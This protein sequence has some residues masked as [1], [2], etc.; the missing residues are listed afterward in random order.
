M[1]FTVE[2]I[3]RNL[4]TTSNFIKFQNSRNFTFFETLRVVRDTWQVLSHTQCA[5]CQVGELVKQELKWG[6]WETCV[7]T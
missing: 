5:T 7:I 1:D 3:S 2:I 4:A 6:S